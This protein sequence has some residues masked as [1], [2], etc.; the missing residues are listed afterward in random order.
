MVSDTFEDEDGAP[1]PDAVQAVVHGLL[2]DK[3][4][5]QANLVLAGRLAMEGYERVPGRFTDSVTGGV[6]VEGMPYVHKPWKCDGEP[7]PFHNPS[8]HHMKAWEWVIRIEKVGLVERTCPHGIG[9]P[10]PDSIWY[11]HRFADDWEHLEWLED[12]GC[13]GCCHV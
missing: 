10:D 1:L 2:A 12:H 5:E 8:D 7:C 9:H 6:V 4:R 3:D 13:D 11:F